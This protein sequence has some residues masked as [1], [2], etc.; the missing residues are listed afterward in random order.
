MRL[1]EGF[2]SSSSFEEVI[3]L[4]SVNIASSIYDTLKQEGLEIFTIHINIIPK[5]SNYFILQIWMR[6]PKDYKKNLN[7]NQS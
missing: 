4:S 5:V 1:L 2:I 3:C 6:K 7:H